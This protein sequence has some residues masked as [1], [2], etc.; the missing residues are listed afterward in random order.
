MKRLKKKN[1]EMKI[2]EISKTIG[3]QF[4]SFIFQK[5]KKN[6]IINEKLKKQYE[7]DLQ[8]YKKKYGDNSM[9]LSNLQKSKSKSPK[10]LRKKKKKN[11]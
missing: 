2:T 9:F 6:Q 3:E 1:P 11:S 5:K 7:K 4:K 8:E 10:I